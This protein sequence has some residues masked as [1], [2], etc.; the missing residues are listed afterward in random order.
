V[1]KIATR[2]LWEALEQTSRRAEEGPALRVGE[3]SWSLA[4]ILEHADGLSR[5]L[6]LE[7]DRGPVMVSLRNSCSAVACLIAAIRS[8]MRPMLADVAWTRPELELAMDR[9]GASAMLWDR[10]IPAEYQGRRSTSPDGALELVVRDRIGAE[11]PEVDPEIAFG[12]FTSG[13]TGAPRCL[14]FTQAAALAAAGEWAQAASYSPEDSLLCL[15]TLGNGLGFN[16]SLLPALLSGSCLAFHQGRLM[17]SAILRTLQAVRPTVLVAFPFV[18][19]QLSASPRTSEHLGALRLAISSAA[20]LTPEAKSAWMRS[21]PV[22]VCDYYGLAEVGPCTFAGAD[23]ADSLGRAL[24]SKS[25]RVTAPDGS[26]CE[27]MVG[28]RVRVKGPTMASDYLDHE[29]PRLD[30]G[31]DQEGFYL[32][33]D[34]GY[35][36]QSGRLFL[37]GRLGREINLAGR[38]VQPEEI[39]AVLSQIHGVRGC[40]VQA[41]SLN[42]QTSIAAYI[43]GEELSREEI[44]EHCARALSVY[45]IP[46][47]IHLLPELPRSSTGKILS[48]RLE[49]VAQGGAL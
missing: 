9:C 41:V 4:E 3:D 18:Y 23:A 5:W 28:G 7:L 30:A 39:E 16:A 38:K 20:R 19:E 35:L 26:E 31:L 11:V 21:S 14:G 6:E 29:Q 37:T 43:E 13:S 40:V 46:Q 47:L 33:K 17:R 44:V 8:G 48:D 1:S 24:G 32:T 45:K 42:Q 49:Q 10:E 15:A 2:T 12:R 36:D 27:P 34:L 25:L 22:P